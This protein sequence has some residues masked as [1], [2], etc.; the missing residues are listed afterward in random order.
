[1]TAA[2]IRGPGRDPDMPLPQ[3]TLKVAGYKTAYADSG[4]QHLG[5]PLLFIHGL[6][7]NATHFVHI[8]SAFATT[9]RVL[10]IDLPACGESEAL[11]RL[12]VDNYAAHVFSFLDTLGIA[13]VTLI[14][15]SLGGMVTMA[16]C[17]RAPE[18]V[19]RAICIS[20]AGFEPPPRWLRP[21]ARAILRPRVLDPLLPRVWKALL[22]QV[23][24]GSNEHTERFMKVVRE[25]Y[26]DEDVGLVSRVMSQLKRD[27]LSRDFTRE[28]RKVKVPF[29]LE[30]GAED[31]LVP[32]RKL[33]KGAAM[34]NARVDEI[35]EC[36]HM[37]IIEKPQAVIRFLREVI[38][39]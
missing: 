12:S 9:R 16:C 1:M 5:E 33:R 39:P 6:A 20:P 38:E 3:F 8:V 13:R 36:G 29:A 34:I 26:R 31:K 35:A 37:P 15:H 17:L 22:G 4:T 11:P 2:E 27:F 18:R 19:S 24:Y 32:A 21:V 25:S 30:W 23:F 7:G 10:A 14:G 28:L